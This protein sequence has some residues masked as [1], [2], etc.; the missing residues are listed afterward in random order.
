MPSSVGRHGDPV[1]CPAGLTWMVE[2]KEVE[3]Q[4]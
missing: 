2:I 1:K 4:A 3:I